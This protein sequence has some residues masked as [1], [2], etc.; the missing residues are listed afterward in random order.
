MNFTFNLIN[1]FLIL[2]S[3]F[4][5]AQENNSEIKEGFYMVTVNKTAEVKTN[6]K[7]K[8]QYID[9]NFV[10]DEINDIIVQNVETY[11]NQ[12]ALIELDTN[13]T[14]TKRDEESFNEYN[15]SSFV[16]PIATTDDEVILGAYL[17]PD[18]AEA[19]KKIPNV[20]KCSASFELEQNDYN[21]NNIMAETR[22]KKV[23]VKNGSYY[24]SPISQGKFDSDVVGK[25]DT[26]YYYPSSAGKDIDIYV[27]DFTFTLNLEQFSND[28]ERIVQCLA[29]CSNGKMQYNPSSCEFDNSDVHGTK[30]ALLAAGT[31]NGAAPKANIYTIAL[32]QQSTLN[33]ISALSYVAEVAIPNKSVILLPVGIR[34]PLDDDSLMDFATKTETYLSLLNQ[35]GVISVTAAGNEGR[36]IDDDVD[37]TRYYPCYSNN[38]ICVSSIDID[39][40]DPNNYYFLKVKDKNGNEK[41]AYNFGYQ[42]DYLVPN[43]SQVIFSRSLGYDS[44]GTSNSCAIAAGMIAT[45]MG[46]RTDLKF[47]NR[48]MKKYLDGHA[49]IGTVRGL[50]S[51]QSNYLINNGK[52]IVFSG[53]G[54]YSGCGIGSGTR[55][56]PSNYCCGEDNKCYPSTNDNCKIVWGCQDD[57]GNCKMQLSNR[58]CGYGYGMCNNGQC[59]SRSGICGTSNEECDFGCQKNY[60]N[61]KY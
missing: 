43:K 9:V 37:N 8:R 50:P 1:I 25:Y 49:L 38:I 30:M 55:S 47:T 20:E 45:I 48:I 40:R 31:E 28:Y 34:V 3:K 24:L 41:Y 13:S 32:K 59:C 46:E 21:V 58:Y 19:V 27:I 14:L 60:G 11:E 39:E 56:C 4:V 29:V 42:V 52:H 10:I 26:N 16:Y 44:T 54:V 22:W 18:L 15:Q 2:F 61:C 35:R 6:G 33:L 12:D 23:S 53:N 5:F 17:N 57:F 36:N 7:V 51:S